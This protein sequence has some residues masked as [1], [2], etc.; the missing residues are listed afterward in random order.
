MCHVSPVTCH[1]SSM[2]APTATSDP[3]PSTSPPPKKNIYI[4]K[5]QLWLKLFQQQK[6]QAPSFA[7]LAIRSSPRSLQLHKSASRP[8]DQVVLHT[9]LIY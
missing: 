7:T 9:S 4:F 5:I 2:P 3:P 8:I 6:K 1:L